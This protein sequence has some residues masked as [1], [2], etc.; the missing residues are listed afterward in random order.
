VREKYCWLVAD[1]PSEQGAYLWVLFYYIRILFQQVVLCTVKQPSNIMGHDRTPPGALNPA[2]RPGLTATS[3][4]NG[5]QELYS[6][7]CN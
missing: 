2:A 7:T 6:Q 1:K 3:V 5:I 4:F